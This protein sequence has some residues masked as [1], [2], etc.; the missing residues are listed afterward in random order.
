MPTLSERLELLRSLGPEVAETA[1]APVLP[2]AESSEAGLLGETLVL[3]GRWQ[4]LALLVRHY[5]VLSPE[6]RAGVRRAS[7]DLLIRA[8]RGA[9]SGASDAALRN[10]LSAVADVAHPSLANL[11][12]D[13]MT[14]RES[15]ITEL[16]ARAILETA[17]RVAETDAVGRNQFDRAIAPACRSFDG[18]RREEVLLAAALQLP[19]AGR[20]LQAWLDD[21][22]QPGIM[23]LRAVVRRSEDA[24][25]QRKLVSMLRTPAVAGAVRQRLVETTD[26][27]TW[28]DLMHQA[29]LT[30]VPAVRA[31]MRLVDRPGRCLPPLS[32]A[33]E[34]D[35]EAQLGFVR[36]IGA[37]KLPEKTLVDRLADAAAFR[38]PL[39]RLGALRVLLSRGTDEADDAVVHFCFDADPAVAA[40][41]VGYTVRRHPTKLGTSLRAVQQLHRSPHAGV[42]DLLAGTAF[43]GASDT[44]AAWQLATQGR[45]GAAVLLARK[46]LRTDHHTMIDS[47]RRRVLSGSRDQRVLAI[48]LVLQLGL[49]DEVELELL[50]AAAGKDSR[51]GAS[52]VSA[53]AVCDSPASADALSACLDHPDA[54]MVANAVEAIDRRLPWAGTVD[55]LV[56]SARQLEQL[57]EADGNRP[58]ANALRTLLRVGCVDP[59]RVAAML[60][61]PRPMHRISGVWLVGK[62]GL[63]DLQEEVEALA[64]ADQLKPVRERAELVAQRL[65]ADRSKTAV[66]IARA[67]GSILFTGGLRR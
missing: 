62:L 33:A 46:A 13:W 7:P 5:D 34:L 50:A 49:A 19:H 39:A 64:Q 3:L 11:A 9:M 41:A 53:L 36:W 52:A 21:E 44:D 10:G 60:D 65:R 56:R 66:P 22:S 15:E 23:P 20:E 43:G 18:H 4:S 31:Q 16:A 57:V 58:R 63:V 51:V 26:A 59:A 25:L 6:V 8:L 2:L 55:A 14:S 17:R 32:S 12:A 24:Q 1:I 40:L 61:D 28:R 35:D 27:E 45:G 29:H 38:S 42:R 30:L 37:L 67:P 54:R 48:Q 47:L